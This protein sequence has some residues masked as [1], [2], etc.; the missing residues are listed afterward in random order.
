MNRAKAGLLGALLACGE[1]SE[2]PPILGSGRAELCRAVCDTFTR[3]EG[4]PTPG[5]MEGCQTNSGGYFR[6][7][8]RAAL[9]AET[10]CLIDTSACPE[11]VT[12]VF[13]ECFL[14]AGEALEPTP[15]A[16]A[17]CDAMSETFF[18]CA[19]YSAP[20][21]CRQINSR[22]V[23][24]ALSAGKRCGNTECDG[25]EQCIDATLWSYGDS[26]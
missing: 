8:T 21:A 9:D 4:S 22:Y 16:A 6:R 11:D 12:D 18:E 19:W 24:E 23:P 26:R 17:F 7:H 5:C 13:S 14:V 10:Q 15:A 3:C 1:G 2:R 25:L 20:T